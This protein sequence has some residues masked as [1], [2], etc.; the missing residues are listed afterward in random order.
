MYLLQKIYPFTIE[1]REAIAAILEH[2]TNKPYPM[3]FI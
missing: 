1:K 3:V 2:N